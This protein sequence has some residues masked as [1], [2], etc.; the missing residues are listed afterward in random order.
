MSSYASGK[1]GTAKPVSGS[2]HGAISAESSKQKNWMLEMQK[3]YPAF[4]EPTTIT[5]ANTGDTRDMVPGIYAY[6][7]AKRERFLMKQQLKETK[8]LAPPEGSGQT[9]TWTPDKEDVDVMMDLEQAR[10]TFEYHRWIESLM[11][12]RLPGNLRWLQENAPDFLQYKMNALNTALKMFEQEAKI[13]M[14]GIQSEEDLQYAFMK[15]NDMLRDG[16]EM[17]D[18][19]R[20]VRGFFNPGYN[21]PGTPGRWTNMFGGVPSTEAITSANGLFRSGPQGDTRTT[22]WLFG[23]GLGNGQG[24][25]GRVGTAANLNYFQTQ[26]QA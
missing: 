18:Q 6:P 22:N 10:R 23:A 20:Y 16:R 5:D 11:D 15:S 19:N 24:S 3:K 17:N 8:A 26:N 2:G 4:V 1:G 14:L 13:K 25:Q 7:D 9:L 12:I 21:V